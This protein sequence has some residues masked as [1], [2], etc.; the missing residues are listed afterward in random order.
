MANRSNTHYSLDNTLHLH[1]QILKKQFDLCL[2]NLP[3]TW[4]LSASHTVER[5]R[6]RLEQPPPQLEDNGFLQQTR[7]KLHCVSPVQIA[8]QSQHGKYHLQ[9]FRGNTNC[10]QHS[11]EL[12]RERTFALKSNFQLSVSSMTINHLISLFG[13]WVLREYLEFFH[14]VCSP[15]QP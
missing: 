6:L 8:Y 3:A 15:T 10:F 1:R 4:S 7:A 11:L 2:S 13:C 5:K 14:W 9:E 12:P